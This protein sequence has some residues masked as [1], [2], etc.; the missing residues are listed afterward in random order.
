MRSAFLAMVVVACS[1]L[2]ISACCSS[3]TCQVK[4]AAGEEL[5]CDG[6]ELSITNLT[7]Q[8][9]RKEGRRV[10]KAEGCGK[11]GIYACHPTNA[12]APTQDK[13]RRGAPDN[14]QT[15]L[16]Y[17]WQCRPVGALTAR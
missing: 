11:S 10:L 1:A 9:D 13:R 4:K 15:A 8:E 16:D 5:G 14:Q 12:I 3:L 17:R 6:D 7:R 2:A